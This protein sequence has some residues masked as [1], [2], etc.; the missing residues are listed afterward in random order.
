MMGGKNSG[1]P[2]Y[3]GND[4]QLRDLIPILANLGRLSVFN[5]VYPLAMPT[6]KVPD[7]PVTS[8][9]LQLLFAL[10]QLSSDSIPFLTQVDRAE[11]T[12]EV[13]YHD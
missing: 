4:R 1:G 11:N 5:K 6:V 7:F 2:N 3:G 8:L 13:G 10:G 9:I 12:R